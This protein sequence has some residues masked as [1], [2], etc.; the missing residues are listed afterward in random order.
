M[1][2]FLRIC[3]AIIIVFVVVWLCAQARCEY[4]TVKHYDDFEHAYKANT[5][6]AEKTEFFKVLSC[7]GQNAKVYYVG[8]DYSDGEILTFVK[9]DGKWVYDEWNKTVW[10]NSGGSADEVIWPYWW[11]FIYKR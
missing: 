3:L 10:T 2:K 5:M 4:L 9:K 1:K 11:H 6:M 7:N 8:K